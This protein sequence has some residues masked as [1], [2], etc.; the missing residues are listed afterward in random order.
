MFAG[1]Q[2]ERLVVEFDAEKIRRHDDRA[3]RSGERD[4]IVIDHHVDYN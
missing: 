4:V 1:H 2:I 3:A